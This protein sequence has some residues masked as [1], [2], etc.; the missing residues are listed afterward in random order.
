MPR[1]MRGFLCRSY[2]MQFQRFFEKTQPDLGE[3][4]LAKISLHDLSSKKTDVYH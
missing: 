2:V 4:K 3:R 1:F